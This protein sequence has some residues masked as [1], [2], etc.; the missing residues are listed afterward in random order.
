VGRSWVVGEAVKLA[1]FNDL[2][3][4]AVLAPP[5]ALPW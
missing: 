2:T 3:F 1:D 5:E 4:R